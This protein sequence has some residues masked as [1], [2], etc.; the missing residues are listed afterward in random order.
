MLDR[1]GSLLDIL[2]LIA[3]IFVAI[4]HATLAAAIESPA[5]RN[6][7]FIAVDDMRTWANYTGEYP[8]SVVVRI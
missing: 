8:A 6:I 1:H 3:L 4:T 2:P 7:L 5:R